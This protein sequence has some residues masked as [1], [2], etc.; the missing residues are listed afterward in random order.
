MNRW[1]EYRIQSVFV[2]LHATLIVGGWLATAT[3]MRAAGYPDENLVWRP[4]SLFVRNWGFVLILLPGIWAAGSIWL[5]N[6]RAELFS[7]RWTIVSGVALFA[8][9]AWILLAA[10]VGGFSMPLLQVN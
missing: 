5:E 3:M 9:L 10:V 4:L 1:Q 6:H 7:K 2:A 8:A